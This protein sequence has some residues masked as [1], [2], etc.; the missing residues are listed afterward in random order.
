MKK[1]KLFSEYILGKEKQAIKYLALGSA[2][3]G[4]GF[5]ATQLTNSP[6]GSRVVEALTLPSG[7]TQ[8]GTIN[9]A[10]VIKSPTNDTSHP[11]FT[12]II[13]GLLEGISTPPYVVDQVYWNSQS[14]LLN[15]KNLSSFGQSPTYV[16]GQ[17][18]F[19]PTDKAI[20]LKT[21]DRAVIKN[22]GSAV[23]T[24]TGKKIPLS[25]GITFQGATAPGGDAKSPVL[26][27]AKSQNGVITL[28]W[29]ATTNVGSGAS[30][31]STEGG[32]IN[33]GTS[34]GTGFW[35]I[36]SIRYT[37]TLLNTDT[38]EVLPNDTLMPIK[39]SDIDASQLATMD[40]KG[41]KGYILS[42]NTALTPSGDG[43]KSS[44]N[45]AIVEDTIELSSNSYI[46]LKQYNSNNVQYKYTDGKN[47]HLDIVTGQFGSTPWNLSDLLGGFI[48]IDKS[49]TQYG[50]NFPNNQYDFSQLTFE[51][52]NKDGKVIDTIK[53]DRNGKGKS[54]RLPAGE[55]TLREKSSNWSSS[56]QTIR[57]NQTVTIP[58][59]DTVTVKPTNTAVQGQISIVKKGKET[60]T[61]LWNNKYTLKGNKFEVTSADGKIKKVLTTDENGKASTTKD[62]PLGP[63]TVREI[64]ASTGFVLSFEEQTVNLTYKDNQT[65][66]VFTTANG[67][68]QEV[69]GDITIKKAG[70][71]SGTSLWNQQYSLEGNEFK[72]TSKTD[73]RVVTVKTNAQGVAK[74]T[75]LPLGEYVIEEVKSSAGLAN[76]FKPQTVTLTYKDQQTAVV[77]GE[78]SGTN[79]EIKGKTTLEK[80]DKETEK[81][82]NGKAN[83][84]TAK[85]QLFYNDTSTGSSPHKVNDPVKWTDVP[86]PKLVKG[87]K[88]TSAIIGGKDVNFGDSIVVDVTDDAL[89]A[90]V[91]NLAL[92]KYYWLEV[93]AGEGYVVDPTKHT[94]ELTKK[95]DKTQVVV[96]EDKRSEEQAIKAR[97][98]LDKM[99]TL[100]NSQGGSGYN[101]IEFTATPLEGT[102]ADPVVFKTG[103]NPI[104]G[105]DGYASGDLVYG[106]WVLNE[107]SG[108]EGYDDIKPVYIHMVTDAKKDVLTITASYYKDFSE[109]FSKRSFAL[110][111]SATE[112]NP[113]SAG[114]VG[115]VTPSVPTISL[116]TLRFN[117]NPEDKPVEPVVL[118]TKD[119]IKEEKGESINEGNVALNSDF[120]YVLNSSTLNAKR[121]EVTEWVI[122]DDYDETFDR[123]NGEYH[124]HAATNFGTYKK[125]DQLPDNFFSVKEEKG[126]LI[127]TAKKAFLKVINDNKDKEVG[128]T[129]HASFYRFGSS[130]EVVNVFDE[131]INDE[132]E[133]SN[134]VNTHTP[135]IEPHKF[136][137]RKEQVDLTG[138]DLLDDDS[139]LEDRYGDT[140]DNPYNDKVD[141]NDQANLNTINVKP[142]QELVYQL[143]LDARPFDATSKL[144]DLRMVDDYDEKS[145]TL[146]VENVK[147]YDAEKKDVTEFFDIEDKDGQLI[148]KAN[149][150]KEGKNSKGETVK[151]IDTEKL[152]LGQ[153]YKIDAPMTVKEDVKEGTDIINT[154]N[155]EWADADGDKGE[156]ITEKRVN[157]V[158]PSDPPVKDV[159]KEE[160]GESI[161][162]GDVALNSDFFY[163][164][165]SSTLK[166]N[167][168]AMTSWSI[169]DN[170]DE[171]FDRYN[172]AFHAHAST[173][174]GEYKKGDELPETFFTAKE[175]KD[176][177]VIFTAT[178]DF[179]KVVNANRDKEV[180]FTIHASFYRY[181]SSDEVINVFTETIDDENKTSNEVETKTP[182][183]EPHKFDL[184]E[185]KYDLS[186]DKLLDDD[187][188]MADRYEES[189]KDPYKDDEKN[190]E[191]ANINTATVKPGQ[192]L[193]YQ[194]WLDA[195]P[196]DATSKLVDLRM[197]DDYDEKSLTLDVENVKVYD[198][199]KK[200]VTEFFDIE[201][202]DGQL[203]V[204]AN[205]FKEG[206]NSKGETVKLIDTEKLALGQYYKID[207]PMTVKEDVKEGTDII[208][209]AN[210]EWTDA[211]GDKG[212]HITEKRVNKVKT[213]SVVKDVAEKAKQVGQA[214]LPQ[215]GDSPATLAI[216]LLGYTVLATVVW[217]KRD[218]IRSFFKKEEDEAY[219]NQE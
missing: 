134:E 195:R 173:D 64:E 149:A 2:I 151:L 38:G 169:N 117:D 111:D 163:V 96:A 101:D 65:E 162:K 63:Y 125:G 203:I 18:G 192:K 133:R 198:A 17:D 172:G 210:Q 196:F 127:F 55:V 138:K 188:E 130:T 177:R 206:K 69:T 194:L 73:G 179:I 24:A 70:V 6:I 140:N 212:E 104:T 67:T 80:V 36:E 207:A 49:T 184:S 217:V 85:Y 71:E 136:D 118:P 175:E 216:K 167:R 186:G 158:D 47:D 187:E 37:I 99:V 119:V 95:D 218:S 27:G 13:S 54:Q 34:D 100:P 90:S 126:R 39:M 62:L 113:N 83:L 171:T 46:V 53:L 122:D 131:M 145:L 3:V 159:I 157:K 30:G 189:N 128:F 193:V 8:V 143:W 121:G 31:G 28:A 40:S 191:K 15:G 86:K 50:K 98:T 66:L 5:G 106:D 147:V 103:V 102:K 20:L 144:V 87:E 12:G 45:G 76:T 199:E 124:V 10:P 165:Q 178:E 58:S 168:E 161:N 152:A 35:F 105:D 93:D 42:K 60:G 11:S 146:D 211:D 201:D 213:P 166:A 183:I 197:V 7:A 88:V 115:Q 108:V 180:G 97:I 120:F 48:E 150:F 33:G 214:V 16:F 123:Y 79:Q 26:M 94:F 141:N 174:F 139:E 156:H 116:S 21:G 135:T 22:V 114:T 153:Y 25:M 82:K 110:Q 1:R 204:K 112:K 52:V 19:N 107:S 32:G 78:T 56:G 91:E 43:F 51:V 109:P 29:G 148:V 170:Y 185:G 23:D 182:T 202:K 77:F 89:L 4:L 209:T 44:S 81:E 9:N 14:T 190:N 137:L 75:H 41:A 72:L 129:I 61:N 215:T 205:A 57:Q 181:K 200:D 84:K 68:N 164:L 132:N 219:D 176:G 142:G 154:A 59:G 208:N 92:G 74:A 155:Q 160:D